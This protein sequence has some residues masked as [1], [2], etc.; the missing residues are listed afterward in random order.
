MNTS[1]S[2]RGFAKVL[3][4]GAAYA[5]LNPSFAMSRP[6]LRLVGNAPTLVRLNSNENPYGPSPMAVKAMTDAFSLAWRYPD[7]HE[8]LLIDALA[9]LNGV[10]HEQILLGNG[11]GEILKVAAAAFTGP[12]KKLL[13]GH[14]TFEAV[15]A[16]AAVAG[17][18]V[19][20][21]N[22]TPDYAHDLPRMLAEK[23]SGLIYICNPNNP[24]AS[25]TPK[26][27]LHGFLAKVPAQTIV[28]VDEAYHHYVES[29]NYESVIP[30]VAQFPNLMVAR[31]FSKIYSMAG[32]RCGYGVARPELVERMR[33]Q[34]TWDSLNIMALV[35]A[36]ASVQDGEQV[37]QGRRHNTE[38]KNYVYSEID[39]SGY[40]YIPSHANFMMINLRR[41]VRPVI[42]AMRDRNVQVGRVF[43]AM[44]NFMRV[45][46]GTRS[47]MEAF[48]SAFRSVM[49]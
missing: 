42:A 34:Q 22:L 31:T 24:T 25:I 8:G 28:L 15:L 38:V 35:A 16:H 4:A 48:V 45:T 5:A 3:G 37:E 40:K 11:S 43:P 1:L 46:V 17:A 39:K 23:S 26:D 30:L 18:E 12:G 14:P 21:I 27:Q 6:T 10:A 20:K 13:V 19:V 32:L 33:A 9:K 29:N 2:R 49:A 41:E 7:E 47:Q 44:P 36:L